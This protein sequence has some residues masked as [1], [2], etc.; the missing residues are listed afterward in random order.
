MP[1]N[2]RLGGVVVSVLVTGPRG[3]GVRTRP[4]RWNFKSDKNPEHTF[5]SE[6]K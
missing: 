3:R 4:T 1:L 5:L 2:S 6:W